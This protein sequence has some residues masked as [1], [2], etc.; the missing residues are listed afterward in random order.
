MRQRHGFTLVELLV[1]VAVIGIVTIVGCNIV[2]ESRADAQKTV[3]MTKLATIGSAF[4]K[5][6]AA[7]G[8]KFAR[9]HTE[10][11]PLAAPTADNDLKSISTNA[12]NQVWPLID[13]GYVPATAFA[14]P[15]DKRWTAK[16][17]TT[18]YGW[19]N[20]G[21]FSYGI[22]YPFDH[23]PAGKAANPACPGSG[24]YSSGGILMA[25]R[26]PGKRVAGNMDWPNHRDGCAYLTMA[27]S[28]FFH[29]NSNSVISGQEIYG[30][31]D[32]GDGDIFPDSAADVVILPNAPMD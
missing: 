10:G 16:T 26:N 24:G 13:G 31:D 2:A 22:Q 32:A 8:G 30:D 14:C 4:G 28:V 9:V 12:M 7:N 6:A 11:D 19:T 5:Y 20:A 25:D 21:E 29:E 17:S 27:G 18:R 1:V 15:A 3:C 23:D